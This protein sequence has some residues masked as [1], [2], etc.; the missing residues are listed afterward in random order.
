MNRKKNLFQHVL[1]PLL[2][3]LLTKYRRDSGLTT[4]RII[5]ILLWTWW[6]NLFECDFQL[7]VVERL[8]CFEEKK[9]ES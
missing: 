9:R 6:L 7:P 3:S 1:L 8:T 5:S 4:S 2:S